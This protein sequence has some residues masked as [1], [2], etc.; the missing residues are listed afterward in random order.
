MMELGACVSLL[1]ECHPLAMTACTENWPRWH[2]LP[3]SQADMTVRPFPCLQRVTLIFPRVF[4][5]L[6]PSSLLSSFVRALSDLPVIHV[7]SW[8]KISRKTHRTLSILVLATLCKTSTEQAQV[9][10]LFHPM[11]PSLR[12]WA[13]PKTINAAR[14]DREERQREAAEL[15]VDRPPPRK[16]SGL[17]SVESSKHA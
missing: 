8:L 2:A 9:G 5:L 15:R 14:A 11:Q 3:R 10:S 4:R 13:V 17:G 16:D 1:E 12:M 7:T 6:V